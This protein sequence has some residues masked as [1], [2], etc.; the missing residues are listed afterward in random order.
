MAYDPTALELAEFQFEEWTPL[1]TVIPDK[2]QQR[3]EFSQATTVLS[4][5][6]QSQSTHV[7]GDWS[8]EFFPTKVVKR[9]CDRVGDDER[10][11]L[12]NFGQKSDEWRDSFVV[13]EQFVVTYPDTWPPSTG[14]SPCRLLTHISRHGTCAVRGAAGP[15]F[16]AGGHF[17]GPLLPARL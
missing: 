11:Y 15:Q 10:G 7:D 13:P 12:L 3:W 1:T 5:L 2:P 6:P 8:M 4:L 9:P 16:I 14:H 17:G